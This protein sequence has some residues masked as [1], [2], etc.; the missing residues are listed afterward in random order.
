MLIAC[1]HHNKHFK[2]DRPTFQDGAMSGVDT[3]FRQW[4]NIWR[5]E[6]YVPGSGYHHLLVDVGGSAGHSQAYDI[7]IYE[8]QPGRKGNE[9]VFSIEILTQQEADAIAEQEAK[10]IS[11]ETV[12][13]F[14]AAVMDYVQK[15]EISNRDDLTNFACAKMS[16]KKPPR[17][18][19]RLILDEMEAN[20]IVYKEKKNAPFQ[21]GDTQ[22]GT[23]T[24]VEGI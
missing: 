21:I 1:H 3:H 20:R 23:E 17:K 14:K 7:E 11:E 4:I 22:N 10:R 13:A 12:E 9:R 18:E 15:H 6:L 24:A 5:P 19:A 16:G 2:G 8:G